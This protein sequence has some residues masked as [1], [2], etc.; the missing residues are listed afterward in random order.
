MRVQVGPLPSEGV[1]LWIAYARDVLVRAR[2]G[3]AP[4]GLTVPAEAAATFDSYLDEWDRTARRSPEFLWVTEVE[5]EQVEYL[6]HALLSM[7][8][9][10]SEAAERRGYEESPPLGDAFYQAMV[11]GFL[12][13]LELEGGSAGKFA[14]ELRDSWPGISEL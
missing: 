2:A 14:E 7:V 6:G 1:T 8:R 3:K 10:L 12:D 4:G 13:A 5:A 11:T 9:V